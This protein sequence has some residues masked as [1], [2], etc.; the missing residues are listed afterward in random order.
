M[1][2]ILLF[3]VV[4]SLI[5]G[6]LG[7]GALKVETEIN[8][9]NT[10]E[11][12]E[13]TTHTV[14]G[15]YGTATWC[16]YC[17]YAHGALKELFAEGQ[18]DF[19]YVSL[20]E[21]KNPK[22]R[23]RLVNDY[24]IRGY[25][26]VYWDGGFDVDVGAGSIPAAKATYTSSINSAGNR[27]VYDIEIDL[28][29]DWLGGTEMEV[30]VEVHNNEDSSYGG[31]IRVYITDKVSSEGW[32]DTDGNLYTY[33]FLDWAFNEELSI[34]AGSSWSDSMT[35]DGSAHGYES[36]TPENTY[37]IA[38]AFNDEWHQG[39]S[40]TPPQN[41]FDAYYTDDVVGAGPGDNE[42][43][44][45]PTITGPTDGEPGI[46]Y[47]YT[48][49]I[50]DPDEDELYV[51]IDWEAETQGWLGPYPSGETLNIMHSWDEAGVYDVKV[52][53][54]DPEYDESVW[55]ETII[56]S[57]GNLAPSKPVID[58]PKTGLI[59]SEI[60]FIFS[61]TDENNDDLLF[62]IEWGDGTIEEWI[63]PY[64]SGEEVKLSH[65]WDEERSFGIKTKVKDPDGAESGLTTHVI[66]IP[67][68]KF[69]QNLYI[70]Q[71]FERFSLIF[72][73]IKQILG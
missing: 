40:Y 21:D 12:G 58:G 9:P 25:P 50:S 33:A 28:E 69:S 8:K 63:G 26:T 11:A 36:V 32:R 44:N 30:A 2:K 29:V 64:S 67:R 45:Q 52:K 24:N 73:I 68:T 5:I 71:L 42:P 47:E 19:Y 57:I 13:R 48:I 27:D 60:E 51:W 1:K 3:F 66:T 49:E 55:S 53:T 37:V 18:L 54:R 61:A 43:P 16:G 72:Q 38:A 35:W 15:E 34:S 17:K 6:G 39:Y 10:E 70:T 20:I 62:Y 46:E 65:S 59:N 22:A 56:V 14:L 23:T 31:T 41:P 4:G 7:A